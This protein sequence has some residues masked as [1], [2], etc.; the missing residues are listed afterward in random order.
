MGLTNPIRAAHDSNVGVSVRHSWLNNKRV[1]NF[2][3]LVLR[4]DNLDQGQ[5]GNAF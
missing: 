3:T 4:R 5:N 2:E 1:Q